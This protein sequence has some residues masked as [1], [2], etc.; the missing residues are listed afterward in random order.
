V[1]NYMVESMALLAEASAGMC[2]RLA[3]VFG[4]GFRRAGLSFGHRVY[5]PLL[6]KGSP[7]HRHEGR[8]MKGEEECKPERL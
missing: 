5:P 4:V 1:V 2:G 6:T 7:T 8:K 3:L